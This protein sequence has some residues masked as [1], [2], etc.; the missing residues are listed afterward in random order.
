MLL[1]AVTAALKAGESLRSYFRKKVSIQTKSLANFVSEADMS[2]ERIIVDIIRSAHPDH[3]VLAEETHHTFSDARH[4]WVVDPLDGTSNFLHGIPHFAVSVGYFRDGQ[5]E[6]GVVYNPVSEDWFYAVQGQGAWH[7][8][9]R[10]SVNQ[11]SMLAD[12]IVAVGFYYDRG[13][14]ME[15]TLEAIADL[16]RENIHGIRRF[17]AAA[18][19]LAQLARGDYG[20][21]VEFK[22]QPWDHAAGALLVREAGGRVTDCRDQ[23]LPIQHPSSVLATNGLLHEAALA[24][25]KGRFESI[26]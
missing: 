2:A 10:L 21:F 15:A 11:E 20:V 16:F 3:A 6:V 1:T 13:K 24:I 9:Q 4:L 14:M 23:R 19:D 26:G 22:L 5:A 18:L 12:T 25:V 8:G 7:N 17:G